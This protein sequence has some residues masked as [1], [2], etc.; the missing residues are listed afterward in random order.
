M[1]DNVEAFTTADG[2]VELYETIDVG[3]EAAT[4]SADDGNKRSRRRERRV[5]EE[6][7]SQPGMAR[8]YL[9]VGRRHNIHAEDIA[10]FFQISGE[11]SAEQIG[12]VTQ[13]DRHSYIN[14]A[15]DV[16]DAA[17]ERLA[18]QE[19]SGRSVRIEHAKPRS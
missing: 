7:E 1:P 17:I 15:E 8:L 2:D 18:D 14:I 6:E 4:E 10:S 12:N 13:R 19:I 16:A 3:A 9:N 5:P 11:L